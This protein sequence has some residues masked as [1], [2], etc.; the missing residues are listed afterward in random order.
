MRGYLLRMY[1]DLD[2]SE[3]DTII[4]WELTSP[5]KPDPPTGGRDSQIGALDELDDRVEK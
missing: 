4:K 1:R 3:L 5:G 2:L